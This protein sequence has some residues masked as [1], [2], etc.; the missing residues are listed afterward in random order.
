M[1]KAREHQVKEK[2]SVPEENELFSDSSSDN[3]LEGFSDSEEQ[4]N[5]DSNSA[6]IEIKSNGGGHILKKLNQSKQNN[7]KKA[8]AEDKKNAELSSIIYI[9]RLPKG[10]HEREL[11]KYFS[12]FGDL[13]QVRLARNK[14]TGNSR[15]YGF[16]E[17]VNRDDAVVAQETM[18]NYLLL[19]HLLKVVNLPK[20]KKIEKLFKHKKRVYKENQIKDINNVKEKAKSKHEKRLEKLQKAGISFTW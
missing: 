8:K 1:A 4:R 20:D 9:S 12:Q 17:F 13:K 10:F 2:R 6:E 16:I 3:E 14:K 11:S 19:G 5:I 7:S 15:H 18:N